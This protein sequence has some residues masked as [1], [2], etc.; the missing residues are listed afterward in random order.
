M[1]LGLV[2]AVVLA[3]GSLLKAIAMVFLGLLLGLVGADVNSGL[4]RFTFG[5]YELS[6][7][8]GVV[9]IA[10]GLFGFSEIINNLEHKETRVVLNA[11]VQKL[12]PSRDD[13]KASWKAVLRG[14]TLGSFLGILPGG[15][16]DKLLRLLHPGKAPGC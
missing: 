13:F 2:A 3:H 12:M 16:H 1:V 8:I 6:D 9:V 7:G 11:K 14:T 15:G 10:M 4:L 5:L